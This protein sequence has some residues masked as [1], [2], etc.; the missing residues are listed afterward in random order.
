MNRQACVFFCLFFL[1][2]C[3]EKSKSALTLTH[4]IVDSRGDTISLPVNLQ[5]IACVDVL[6]YSIM[7]ILRETDK[8]DMMQ[9][10]NAPWMNKVRPPESRIA[11]IDLAPSMEELLKRHVEVVIGGYGGKSEEESLTRVSIPQVRAQPIQDKFLNPQ[12]YL[13]GEKHMLSVYAQMLGSTAS[14]RVAEWN[15]WIDSKVQYVTS[16]TDHLSPSH[17]PRVYFAR[18][19]DP[20][21]THGKNAATYWFGE[22]AGADMVVKNVKNL[23]GKGPVHM[24]D[25]VRFDPEWIFVGRQYPIEMISQNSCWKNISAVRNHHVI[26]VPGGVFYWDSSPESG[27]LL[28]FYAKTLHPELFP[29]LDLRKEIQHFY[30]QFYDYSL[31]DH[32]ADLIIQGLGPDGTRATSPDA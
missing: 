14:N 12:E 20:L 30:S 3:G 15:R 21:L 2:G 16:R 13:D 25:L 10:T 19:P 27:L 23:H 1:W 9:E 6:C 5:R 32:D 11:Q 7:V 29:D 18:G 8:I 28:L 17:R 31:S 4:S 26:P 22:M 24:E